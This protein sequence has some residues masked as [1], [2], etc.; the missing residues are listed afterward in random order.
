MN[1]RVDHARE[2]E[3]D[4]RETLPTTPG[5]MPCMTWWCE[6]EAEPGTLR[7]AR[8]AHERTSGPPPSEWLQLQAEQL[9]REGA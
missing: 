3:R 6:S 4:A 8:H 9:R 7:C 5:A 2:P 1:R